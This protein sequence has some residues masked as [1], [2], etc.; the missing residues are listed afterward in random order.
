MNGAVA[1]FERSEK[2]IFEFSDKSVKSTKACRRRK[3]FEVLTSQQ[4][5]LNKNKG[6]RKEKEGKGRKRKKKEGK[7]RK[8]KKKGRKGTNEGIEYKVCE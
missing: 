1:V 6:K 8:R 7:G 5:K 3:I 2:K 4:A